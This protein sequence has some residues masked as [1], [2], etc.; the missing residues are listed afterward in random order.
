MIELKFDEDE[1]N[2]APPIEDAVLNHSEN[3][4]PIGKYENGVAVVFNTM[5][6]CMPNSEYHA[7]GGLSSTKFPL[8][9]LSV[10]A[11]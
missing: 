3:D 10:R 4:I 6:E 7:F 2:D 9:D 8:I 11:F 1:F 5:I